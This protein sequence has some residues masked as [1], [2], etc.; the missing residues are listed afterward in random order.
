MKTMPKRTLRHAVAA[1]IVAAAALTVPNT[2]QAD[3]AGRSDPGATPAYRATLAKY[4][5]QAIDWQ[6]CY[7]DGS[8]PEYEC[9]YLTA[10]LDWGRPSRGD[11]DL[12][13]TRVQATGTRHGIVLTN[14]GGPG[15]AGYWVPLYI[16]DF[17][18]EVAEHYDVLGMDPRGTFASTTIECG[19]TDNLTKLDALD[20]LDRSAAQTARFL[21]RS[22]AEADDCARD[23]ITAYVNTDQT[24]RDL[25]LLRATL[26]EPKTSYLG[27]SAGTWLGA[28]YA[29]L[30]PSRVDRFL[31]DANMDF[32]RPAYQTFRAQPAAFQRRLEQDFFPWAA[33]YHSLYHLGR[34]AHAVERTYEKRRAALARNPLMLT[35]GTAL[36]GAL[37]DYGTVGPLYAASLFPDLGAALSTIERYGH[38]DDTAREQV[39]SVFGYLGADQSEHTFWATVC[40][41]TSTSHD[42]VRSDW[43]KF[44]K[45]P[46]TGATWLNNP[47]PFWRLPAI[48][49]PVT[50]KGIPPVLMLQNDGDPATPYSAGQAA[51]VRT[52]GSVLVSVKNEGD[53]TIYGTGNECVELVADRWLVDGRLP[54]KDV[55][56]QGL[57]LPDPTALSAFRASGTR[58]PVSQWGQEF[59]RDHAHPGR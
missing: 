16:E 7:D 11:I 42:Q 44:I 55:T 8:F 43:A 49:S 37:Y 9:A 51:H 24:A 26:G 56:C 59:M 47:C 32:T 18:P 4:A 41:D 13:I 34:T 28:W 40:N 27:W 14:P 52:P 33:K 57:P 35:D 54:R 45:Y 20:G 21:G 39:A 30:F 25:D 48:G 36:T 15:Q 22:K 19:G 23:P 58:L 12:F 2:I 6:P 1:L 31:L 46:L 17:E 53:H 5:A 38:A 3:A 50:G 10:P 29:T